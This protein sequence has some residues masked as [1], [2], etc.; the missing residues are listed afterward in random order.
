MDTNYAR[1]IGQVETADASM[2]QK[3][4][5]YLHEI[6]C[7]AVKPEGET[8]NIQW[9]AQT[10]THIQICQYPNRVRTIGKMQDNLQVFKSC[11]AKSPAI[12][13]NADLAKVNDVGH[14]CR[15]TSRSWRAFRTTS[16]LQST[17]VMRVFVRRLADNMC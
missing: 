16:L 7:M 10:C 6:P 8:G 9:Y 17:F 3:S 5:Q 11:V 12:G 14:R 1:A 13:Q 15:N 2:V 4:V